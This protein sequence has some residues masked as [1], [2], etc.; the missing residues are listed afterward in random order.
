MHSCFL[1]A[2]SP[3]CDRALDM[4]SS[5]IF[6]KLVKTFGIHGISFNLVD[7]FPASIHHLVEL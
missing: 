5:Y 6:A 7:G 2:I 4:T 3:H 1:R